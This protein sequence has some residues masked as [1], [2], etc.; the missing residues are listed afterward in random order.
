M[1]NKKRIIGK[2]G[3]EL[4]RLYMNLRADDQQQQPGKIK[5]TWAAT[6]W[7][8]CPECKKVEVVE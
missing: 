7:A 2:C 6:I 1:G 5:R 4:R 3:H 8:T